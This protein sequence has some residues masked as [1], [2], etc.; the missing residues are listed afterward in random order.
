M[1]S[2]PKNNISLDPWKSGS[3][4]QERISFIKILRIFYCNE[5]DDLTL[6]RAYMQVFY[7]VVPFDFNGREFLPPTKKQYLAWI[8]VFMFMLFQSVRF[9]I[10]VQ[11]LTQKSRV[12]ETCVVVFWCWSYISTVVHLYNGVVN[13]NHF[14]K[15]LNSWIQYKGGN[16]QAIASS[17]NRIL[18]CFKF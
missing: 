12:D 9:V 2:I 7:P 14:T 8:P 15:T 4:R 6:V 16:T 10:L 17:S 11:E 1:F 5:G 3:P 18:M 13:W